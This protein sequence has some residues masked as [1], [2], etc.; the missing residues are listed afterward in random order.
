MRVV[1]KIMNR[2]D[3]QRGELEAQ[4][5]K[6][7]LERKALQAEIYELRLNFTNSL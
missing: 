2:I 3:V 1:T 4:C 7:E 6:L 5:K